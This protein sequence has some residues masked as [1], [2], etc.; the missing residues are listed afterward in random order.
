MLGPGSTNLSA[1]FILLFIQHYKNIKIRSSYATSSCQPFPFQLLLTYHPPSLA[2]VVC[3]QPAG[4]RPSPTPSRRRVWCTVSLAPA[5]TALSAPAGA[6]G[7]AGRATSTAT[8]S[9][10]DA[11]TTSSTATSKSKPP[12]K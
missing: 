6:P 11:A 2:S 4:R 10:E 5:G 12:S 9:G 3:C 7:R 8:G 1:I